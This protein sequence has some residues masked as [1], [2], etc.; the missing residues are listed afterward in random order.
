M[1]IC[2]ENIYF[3]YIYI[4]SYLYLFYYVLLFLH[5]EYAEVSLVVH[6]IFKVFHDIGL[7]RIYPDLKPLRNTNHLSLILFF[8]SGKRCGEYT[9]S[10]PNE[11]I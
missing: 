1:L 10:L 7:S 11:V 4:C 6:T 8:T 5:F 9:H 3:D 2:I